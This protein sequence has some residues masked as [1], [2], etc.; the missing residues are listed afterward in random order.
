V[1]RLPMRLCQTSM[2]VYHWSPA[3]TRPAKRR[4]RELCRTPT[5]EPGQGPG[6]ATQQTNVRNAPFNITTTNPRSTARTW[7]RIKSTALSTISGDRMWELAP[8]SECL[9]RMISDE[10]STIT[11]SSSNAARS[12]G[13]LSKLK[14]A[15]GCLLSHQLLLAVWFSTIST[16]L[17]RPCLGGGGEGR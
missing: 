10:M 8:T 4:R 1:H 6:G 9:P 17:N 7:S 13:L 12:C 3:A 14:Q 11:W 16:T 5:G 2:G 15:S